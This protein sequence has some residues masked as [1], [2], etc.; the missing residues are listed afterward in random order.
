MISKNTYLKAG[1]DITKGNQLIDN[2][3]PL[4][5]NTHRDEVISNLGGF[6]ALFALNPTKYKNPVLVSGAD[7]VG[8]KLLIAQAIDKHDTIGI[9]LVAMCVNDILCQGAE[10]LFFLDYFATGKLDI[11]TT[12]EVISGISTACKEHNVSLVGGET[13]EMP[14]MYN[15]N[16]YDLAGF[17]VGIVEK[18]NILP[19][20]NIKNG[21]M[22]IGLE[23]SGLHS[24]GF[25]L[26]RRTLDQLKISLHD[27]SPW[28]GQ[29]WGE[30]LLTPTSI[31]VNAVL[32]IIKNVAGIAHITGG[33]M[34]DNIPRMFPEHLTYSLEYN[35]WPEIFTWLQKEGK[36]STEEML[37]VFNCGIGMVLVT[38]TSKC[39]TVIKELQNNNIH[40]KVIGQVTEK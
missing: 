39:D 12:K 38:N 35:D 29:S 22:L 30:L 25:S 19:S 27:T 6:S 18:S 32:K 14:D 4:I 33:G 10:P 2:I 26:L 21:D 8:T 9:D 20:R 3:K 15:S 11:K 7:G 5:T 23:S 13:A 36:I 17:C 24:N 16:K 28:S 40:A 34:L 1:V 37:R 31:Y